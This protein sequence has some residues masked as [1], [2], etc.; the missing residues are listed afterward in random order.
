M[1]QLLIQYKADVN[2]KDIDDTSAIINLFGHCYQY[3]AKLLWK[4][5]KLLICNDVDVTVANKNGGN[6]LHGV[7]P[8]GSFFPL[9]AEVI[10]ILLNK[11][12]DPSKAHQDSNAPLNYIF[13]FGDVEVQKYTL[14]RFDLETYLKVLTLL[15]KNNTDLS[16]IG[17]DGKTVL[18]SLVIKLSSYLQRLYDCYY[19]ENGQLILEYMHKYIDIL[20]RHGLDVNVQDRDGF[21]PLNYAMLQGN[22]DIAFWI[23]IS[24]GSRS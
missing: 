15:A 8:Y 22:Y 4:V 24:F 12:V 5:F 17:N 23:D 19:E 11:G 9:L 3:N 16:H 14:K 20:L 2:S 6:L 1:I 21:T 18:H 13:H 10:E 7:L